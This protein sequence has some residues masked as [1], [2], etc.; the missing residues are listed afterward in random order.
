[1]RTGPA[2]PFFSGNEIVTGKSP[3]HVVPVD[4]EV[5]SAEKREAAVRV[6]FWRAL[7]QAP[8]GTYAGLVVEESGAVGGLPA[9]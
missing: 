8:E 4:P 6:E 2:Q 5:A 3:S 1:M 7:D 9:V